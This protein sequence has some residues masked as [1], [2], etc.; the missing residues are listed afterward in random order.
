MSVL[1]RMLRF[2]EGVVGLWAG[3]LGSEVKREE[4][5]CKCTYNLCA[6]SCHLAVTRQRIGKTFYFNKVLPSLPSDC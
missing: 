3:L 4:A 6:V 1:E 5:C 2:T